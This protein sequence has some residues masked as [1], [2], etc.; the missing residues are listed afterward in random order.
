MDRGTHLAFYAHPDATE[1]Q[2]EARAFL[3]LSRR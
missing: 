2:E 3:E 1:V